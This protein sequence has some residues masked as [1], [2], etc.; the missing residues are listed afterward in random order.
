MAGCVALIAAAGSGTRLG[1]PLP[2]GDQ[3]PGTAPPKQY[4]TL[5]GRP[6][7]AHCA[8]AFL[9]SGGVDAVAAVIG[10]DDRAFY[11]E[12]VGHLPLREPV[13]G[14]PTRQD[15]VRRG[16]ESLS[17]AG[18]D[19]VLIHDGARPLVPRDVIGRTLAALAT[20]DGAV[21]AIA[22]SDS[23][24]RGA[25]N[26]I[27][28]AVDRA[29]LYRAQT[30]QGFHFAA[31][32][33]AHRQAA[34]GGRTDFTDDAAVAAAAGL[35]IALVEGSEDNLKITTAGDLARAERMLAQGGEVRTG[36]GLDVHAFGEPGS[37]PVR[38]GGIDIAFDRGLAGHS[39]ADA[40]LHA[41]TD[42]ILGALAEGDIGSHFPP[43]ESAWKDADSAT[44]LSHA[45]ALLKG[46]GGVLVNLDLTIICE[47]PKIAP[48]RAAMRARIAEILATTVERVSVKA[49]TTEGLGALGRGDGI[50]AQA[51]ATIR[52][53]GGGS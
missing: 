29:G 40:A 43:T 33:A 41:A 27:V 38:L 45:A 12:A 35:R 44:F 10:A 49:T 1:G 16:L 17:D 11:D 31:I 24:K 15:S 26:T 52:L 20:H 25:D 8:T 48:H 28:E 18:Y 39:D 37:G 13:I 53:G 32:L 46:R 7:L 21:P 50:A 47:A 5:A 19:T 23:L 30:P 51:V 4:R 34:S 6:L 36:Q 22:V 2:G 42:A 3:P 14:G 9:Q